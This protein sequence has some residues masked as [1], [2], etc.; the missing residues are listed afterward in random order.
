MK[1]RFHYTVSLSFSECKKK[2]IKGSFRAASKSNFEAYFGHRSNHEFS[3]PLKENYYK[4]I[5]WIPSENDQLIC[6]YY[7]KEFPKDIKDIVASASFSKNQN[8]T[9]ITITTKT[10][11]LAIIIPSLMNLMMLGALF[12]DMPLL[13]KIL[14]AILAIT[15][16][17]LFV[18]RVRSISKKLSLFLLKKVQNEML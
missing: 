6:Y 17:T 2:L 1:F 9:K 11:P 14:L 10:K 13:P 8:K 16:Q 18:Y 4:I 7:F 12:T 15:I 5:E 3:G